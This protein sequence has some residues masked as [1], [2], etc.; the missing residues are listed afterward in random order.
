V[1]HAKTI[2]SYNLGTLHG[3][4][5]GDKVTFKCT[6]IIAQCNYYNQTSKFATS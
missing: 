3:A 5:L 2:V 1:A 6:Y 4:F